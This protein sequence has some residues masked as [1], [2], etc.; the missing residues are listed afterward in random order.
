M[1]PESSFEPLTRSFT[2][3]TKPLLLV[4]HDGLKKIPNKDFFNKVLD[5]LMHGTKERKY[6]ISLTKRPATRFEIDNIEE[7]NDSL[8][9]SRISNYDVDAFLG[10]YHCPTILK[11]VKV[12]RQIE[13]GFL[14]E[15]EVLRSD[16][17][18]Y[19]LSE[20][21]YQRLNLNDIKDISKT[22]DNLVST[23]SKTAQIIPE[24]YVL[25]ILFNYKHQPISQRNSPNLTFLYGV[26]K[27]SQRSSDMTFS[28]IDG[29]CTLTIQTHISSVST[30]K[31]AWDR[32]VVLYANKSR[33]RIMSLKQRLLENSAEDKSVSTYMQE[34]RGIADDLALVNSVRARD[35][36]ISFDKIH[37]KLVDY[38]MQQKN[39]TKVTTPIIPTANYTQR[40]QEVQ[41][42]DVVLMVSSWRW[43]GC[44]DGDETVQFQDGEVAVMVTS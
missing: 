22:M 36:P 6:A 25:P 3:F 11:D 17:K 16:V 13:Y 41:D 5:Y 37:E 44:G 19:T 4:G 21:D 23:L 38:E 31:E 32:L 33:T 39:S 1:N 29:S 27:Y 9:R 18:E 7:Y 12:E 14:T 26:A 40:D 42:C 10:I 35:T 30:S 34:M 20:S 28:I 8:F 15:I 2:N 24:N 43:C